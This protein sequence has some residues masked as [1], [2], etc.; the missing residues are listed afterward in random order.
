M[1]IFKNKIFGQYLQHIANLLRGYVGS[2]VIVGQVPL[3]EIL[4]FFVGHIGKLLLVY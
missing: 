3:L 2:Y 1:Y 4:P